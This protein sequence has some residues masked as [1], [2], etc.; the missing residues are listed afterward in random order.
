[1][2]ITKTLYVPNRKSW[3]EWLKKNCRKEKEIWLV[4]YC[5][6]AGKPRVPYND[7]VE[8]ALSSAGSTA[9]PTSASALP[10]STRPAYG[11]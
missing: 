2:K 1:M 8:E 3:R 5:K 7:A 4:Y 6:E 9:P 10:T 11:R